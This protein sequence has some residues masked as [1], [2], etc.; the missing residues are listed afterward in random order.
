MFDRIIDYTTVEGC[1]DEIAAGKGKIVRSLLRGWRTFIGMGFC[2]DIKPEYVV[3]VKEDEEDLDLRIK[4]I[5]FGLSR[6]HKKGD[7]YM[8][9]PVGTAYFR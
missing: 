3:F 8:S 7:A 4:L 9:N 1:F 6:R 5:D 2:I